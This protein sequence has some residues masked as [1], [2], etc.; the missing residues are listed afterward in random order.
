LD[1]INDVLDLARMEA[2][3]TMIHETAVELPSILSGVVEMLRPRAE[4]KSL[5]FRVEALT[6]VPECI[7]TD[8]RASPRSF[9]PGL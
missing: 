8:F 1:Y 6:P 5:E 3:R 9:A 7:A 4:Q 2:G